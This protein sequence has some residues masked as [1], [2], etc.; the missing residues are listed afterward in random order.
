MNF[1]KQT[2]TNQPIINRLKKSDEQNL[3]DGSLILATFP[4]IL[5]IIVAITIM[6]LSGKLPPNLPL[7]YSLPW[8]ENQLAKTHQLLIIPATFLCVALI[9]LIIYL[10]INDNYLIFKR[11]LSVTSVIIS[12]VF[13]I[14][15]FQI[16]S[17]FV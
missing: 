14:S 17:I 11:I 7:F 4:V 3:S 13:I 9:N 16:I 1:A 12:L 10:Q 15:L 8:G 5:A 2:L 6:I